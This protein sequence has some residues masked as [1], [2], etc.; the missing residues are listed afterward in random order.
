MPSI[1]KSTM[2]YT[3]IVLIT[4]PPVGLLQQEG[5]WPAWPEAGPGQGGHHW[6]PYAFQTMRLN[7]WVQILSN[8]TDRGHPSNL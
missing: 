6:V 2:Y 1:F 5:A 7:C 3:E 4:Y 8:K